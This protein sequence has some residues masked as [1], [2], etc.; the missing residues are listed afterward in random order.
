MF[1]ADGRVRQ[2]ATIDTAASSACME[3][4]QILF[5]T[6]VP[7]QETIRG[8]GQR[9]LLMLPFDSDFVACHDVPLVAGSAT[10]LSMGLWKRRGEIRPPKPTRERKPI[11]SAQ[12]LAEGVTGEVRV[13]SVLTTTGCVRSMRVIGSLHPHLDWA[14]IRALTA[15]RFTPATRNGQPVPIIVRVLINFTMK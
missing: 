8:D 11:Y 5:T 1:G 15:W 9:A 4:A 2:L 7:S 3:A 14:A 6:Y 10:A 12:A 13:E